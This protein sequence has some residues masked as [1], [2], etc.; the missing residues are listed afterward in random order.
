MNFN[1]LVEKAEKRNK[2]TIAVAAAE[3]IEVLEAVL[4]ALK[5]GLAKFLLFGNK[6]EINRLMA[7]NYPELKQH[8]DL[9]I[10]H[11]D[12]SQVAALKAV[13]A[14]RN[15][16]ADVLMKGNLATSIIL[17]AVLNK[18]TGLRSGKVLSHLAVFEF[19]NYKKW[20]LLTDAAMNIAPTVEQKAEIIINAVTVANALEIRKPKVVPLAAIETVNPAMSATMDAAILTQM[21]QRGQIANCIVDG[22]LALDVAISPFA[23]EHKKI[24]SKVAGDADILVVPS[25]EVGN[26]LY[27][28]FVYFAKARVGAVVTGATAPIVLT[29]RSDSAE[30]KLL[31][32]ILAVCTTENRDLGGN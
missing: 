1:Q 15:K 2:Q 9:E 7:K 16:Q 4:T 5:M 13:Q 28:S 26:V 12:T 18:E 22:P 30:S 32:L 10:I 8:P 19:Q 14:V 29:S 6:T 31:S 24:N 17:K 3:D 11:S 21:N 27:K 25:I 20:I 23:A